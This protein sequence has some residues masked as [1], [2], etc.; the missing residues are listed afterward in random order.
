MASNT[1]TPSDGRFP[2]AR[3]ADVAFDLLKDPHRRHALSYLLETD[4]PAELAT[5]AEHVAAGSGSSDR[6]PTEDVAATR[7]S[8][9]HS[10]LPRMEDAD[11]IDYDPDEATVALTRRAEAFESAL[12]TLVRFGR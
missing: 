3:F 2:T 12:S 10:H 11:V 6:V 1:D 9:R 8:L 4:G 5:L 7:T